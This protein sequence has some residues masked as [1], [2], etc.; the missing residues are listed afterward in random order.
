MGY[1][2]YARIGNPSD[3]QSISEES[4]MLKS[5]LMLIHKSI[6][7][8]NAENHTKAKNTPNLKYYKFD[9]YSFEKIGKSKQ[10]HS[11]LSDDEKIIL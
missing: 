4:P 1:L 2:N 10:Y 7:V 3:F 9:K 6:S 8:N 11:I 5:G